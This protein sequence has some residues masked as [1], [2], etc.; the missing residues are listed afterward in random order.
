MSQNPLLI[1]NPADAQAE[2]SFQGGTMHTPQMQAHTPPMS[3]TKLSAHRIFVCSLPYASLHRQDGKKLPFVRGY[4]K[5]NI[6]E[7]IR[8][9]EHEILTGNPYIRAGNEDD[10]LAAESIFNPV[11]GLER[12]VRSELEASLRVEI[13]GKLREE[14]DAGKIAGVDSNRKAALPIVESRPAPL[15]GIV[16][17][18][19]LAGVVDSNEAMKA[20]QA[21][22]ATL[23]K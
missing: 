22:L 9:L 14:M 11:A 12:K 23:K 7:D 8:Y 15:A 19:N 21:R 4:L 20:A 1:P 2:G 13:E 10:E 18:G 5:T 3:N 17:S 6:A 16:N